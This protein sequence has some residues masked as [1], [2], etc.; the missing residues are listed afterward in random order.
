MNDMRRLALVTGLAAL[1]LLSGCGRDGN[2]SQGGT[3]AAQADNGGEFIVPDGIVDNGTANGSV[4]SIGAVTLAA[5]GLRIDDQLIAFETPRADTLDA[6]RGVLGEQTGVSHNDQCGAGPMDMAEFNGGLTLYFLEGRFAGWDVA[7]DGSGS[8]TSPSGVGI[9]ST[10]KAM[11]EK[12][13]VDVQA[14]SSLG[15]EFN[16]GG[17][18]GLLSSDTPAGTVTRLWAGNSC[19]F[20]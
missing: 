17:L 5:R 9:G 13:S 6:V 2:E 1:A 14:S 12:A 15:V 18:S 3:S 16:T 4:D 20:R 19:I 8:F 10:L 7:P 11:R